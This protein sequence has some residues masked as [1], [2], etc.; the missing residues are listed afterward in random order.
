LALV[1]VL[2]S[3]TLVINPLRKNWPPAKSRPD[4]GFTA[5]AMVAALNIPR[6]AGVHDRPKSALRRTPLGV[7]A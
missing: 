4:V 5:T 1:H 7:A 3:S 2:P 6:F